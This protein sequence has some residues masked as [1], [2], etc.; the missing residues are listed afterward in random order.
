[1]N[2]SM[3]VMSAM[4]KGVNIVTKISFL[5]VILTLFACDERMNRIAPEMAATKF[6][7]DLGLK[8]QGRPNCTSSDTDYDGYVTCTIALVVP[9]NQPV[10]TMSLQCAV[11]T[12]QYNT[13]F[14]EGCKETQLKVGVQTNYN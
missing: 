8:I 14:A 10:K 6:C 5:L 3:I 12:D 7:S 11:I 4:M 2:L 9:E 13:V 1:M